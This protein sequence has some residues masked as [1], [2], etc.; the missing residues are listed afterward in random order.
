MN[1]LALDT[2]TERAAVAVAT[3]SGAVRAAPEADVAGRHGRNLVP[4]IGA[5]LRAGGPARPPPPHPPGARPLA[6][7]PARRPLVPRAPLP[8]PQR[9]RG[10]VEGVAAR[11]LACD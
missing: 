11:R 4:A 3:A 5:A 10:A 1:I 2:S 7:R 8:P 6:G 9:G